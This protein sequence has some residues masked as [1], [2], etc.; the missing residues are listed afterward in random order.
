MSIENPNENLKKL[1]ASLDR[2][3][4]LVN[5]RERRLAQ[6]EISARQEKSPMDIAR[7]VWSE[8]EAQAI[9]L[10]EGHSITTIYNIARSYLHTSTP[11]AQEALKEIYE[12]RRS[13]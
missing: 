12:K 13:A 10:G 6:G 9:N 1:A 7:E 8:A 11:A 3:D 5:E 4:R 2:L